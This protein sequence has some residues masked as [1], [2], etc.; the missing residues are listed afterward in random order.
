M[1][2]LDELLHRIRWDPEFGKG[3]FTIG[4]YDRVAREEKRVPFKMITLD[5]DSR[6]FS[7]TDPDEIVRHIPLHRVNTVYKNGV[8][9]WQRP[10][11]TINSR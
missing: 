4:Y 10:R 3:H 5:S 7:F 1:Q 9:I 6:N 11:R 8:V 2:P